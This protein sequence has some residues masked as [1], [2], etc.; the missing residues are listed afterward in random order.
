VKQEELNTNTRNSP[1]T[2]E[3]EHK[4]EKLN[5]EEKLTRNGRNWTERGEMEQEIK[6]RKSGWRNQLM[7]SPPGKLL[8]F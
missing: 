8:N 6:Q 1:E 2:G 3:T 5:R 7:N 4:Q